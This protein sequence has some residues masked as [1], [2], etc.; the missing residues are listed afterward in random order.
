MAF[1]RIN[2]IKKLFNIVSIAILILS[3]VVSILWLFYSEINFEPALVLLGLMYAGIPMLGGW[4]INRLDKNLEQERLTL[5][6][7]LAYGYLTNYLAPV[8]RALRK[9]QKNPENIKFFVYIPKT[10]EEFYD[11]RIIEIISEIENKDYKVE[12]LEIVIDHEKRAKDYRT[13]KRINSNSPDLVYFDFP[14]TL[15]TLTQA[16][17]YKIET[18]KNKFTDQQRIELSTEYITEFKTKLQNMLND[19]SKGY[20]AIRNNIVIDFGDF[21]FIERL[22]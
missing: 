9:G 17:D 14:T 16:I 18:Q 4:V 13:A 7:A 2:F 22:K 3:I 19:D 20:Q 11:N 15:L 10:L 6:Y 8:V 21:D 12:K 1:R 5:P